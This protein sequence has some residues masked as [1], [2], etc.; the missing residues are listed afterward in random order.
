VKVLVIGNPAAGH[1]AAGGRAARLVRALEARGHQVEWFATR[2]PGDARR[3]AAAREG[4]VD[5]IV[6]AG[7]DGTLNEVLNGLAEPT[8]T[9]LVPMAL[10]TANMLAA[11][12]GLPAAPEALAEVV[13]SG[14]LRRLDLG[15][16]RAEDREAGPTTRFAS[17]AGV[18][19]DALVTRTVGLRRR[20]PLGYRGYAAP[21]LRTLARYR[22]PRLTVRLDGG[23]PLPCGFLIVSRVPNYGGIFR[24]APDARPD[25]GL[26]HA[27][28][29]AEASIPALVRIVAPAL[30]GRLAGAPGVSVHRATRIRVDCEGSAAV[31]VDGD[32][33]GPTPVELGLDVGGLAV[34]VASVR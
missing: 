22:A 31:Q 28:L 14:I 18:G 1:G 32:Y 13:T 27:C 11:A 23:T 30:R 10:G 12:L 3:Q 25:D 33:W 5:C 4:G 19:F 6:T 8:A 24:V 7:G 21:I 9:P 20:G 17:V 26:L 29:F 2:A 16:V 15:R 34:L